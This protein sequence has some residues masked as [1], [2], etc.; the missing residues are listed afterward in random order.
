MS[1]K[2]HRFNGSCYSVNHPVPHSLMLLKRRGLLKSRE[3]RSGQLLH[4]ESFLTQTF[5]FPI[6]NEYVQRASVP[7][8]NLY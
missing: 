7:I 5:I 6:A 2:K 8:V 4:A 1:R 3:Q